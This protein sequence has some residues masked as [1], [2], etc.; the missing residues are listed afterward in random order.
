MTFPVFLASSGGASDRR[1]D[2]FTFANCTGVEPSTTCISC[3]VTPTGYN[4]PAPISISG[5]GYSIAGGAFTC[6]SGTICPGQNL[7]LCSISS[8]SLSNACNTT[9]C[10]GCTSACTTSTWSV[11]TRALDVVPSNFCACCFT[12]LWGA[13]ISYCVDLTGFDYAYVTP[14]NYCSCISGRGFGISFCC[15]GTCCLPIYSQC[16]GTG[17]SGQCHLVYPGTRICVFSGGVDCNN[18]GVLETYCILF[19]RAGQADCYM[20]GCVCV[21]NQ[22]ALPMCVMVGLPNYAYLYDPGDGNIVYCCTDKYFIEEG[23]P[24]SSVKFGTHCYPNAISAYPCFCSSVFRPTCSIAYAVIWSQS[25]YPQMLASYNGGASW[26]TCIIT[27]VPNYS[28][29]AELKYL[30]SNNGIGPTCV[31]PCYIWYRSSACNNPSYNSGYGAYCGLGVFDRQTVNCTYTYGSPACICSDCRTSSLSNFCTTGVYGQGMANI[32]GTYLC[33]RATAF[34]VT[35]NRFYA[36]WNVFSGYCGGNG[37]CTLYFLTHTTDFNTWTQCQLPYWTKCQV[38]IEVEALPPYY[39]PAVKCGAPCAALVPLKGGIIIKLH[40]G[41]PDLGGREDVP[42][43]HCGA[44]P[45]TCLN[46]NHIYTPDVVNTGFS[47]S[48]SCRL[49]CCSCALGSAGGAPAG[50]FG[51]GRA[52]VIRVRCSYGSCGLLQFICCIGSSG[53]CFYSAVG[54]PCDSNGGYTGG[55]PLSS[56][57]IVDG[58]MLVGYDCDLILYNSCSF[59]QICCGLGYGPMLIR[60]FCSPYVCDFYSGVI[61]TNSCAICQYM[62]Q[63]S[64][65]YCLGCAKFIG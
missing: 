33:L 11:T 45:G 39:N 4:A 57:D 29:I 24:C 42:T 21:C 51:N 53:L 13:G 62:C 58:A 23:A 30:Q 15:S 49:F 36:L 20:T 38:A 43:W 9:V 16:N 25:G 40:A 14:A 7:R 47:F 54:G 10:I 6:S 59:N 22:R 56:V 18:Q 52:A 26:C 8:S 3:T 2:A 60:T 17:G 32:V 63:Y 34:D 55:T 1:P 61:G 31:Y 44:W 5:G 12:V 41:Y 27:G 48:S 37:C 50:M 46:T 64:K 19:S 35:T 28:R 65:A